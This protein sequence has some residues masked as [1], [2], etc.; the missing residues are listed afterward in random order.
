MILGD[1]R[2]HLRIVGTLGFN[3]DNGYGEQ[4]HGVR[5]AQLLDYRPGRP[6]L[7][8]DGGGTRHRRGGTRCRATVTISSSRR[9]VTMSYLAKARTTR[10]SAATATTGSRAA[11]ATMGSGDDGRI[12]ASR[13]STAFGEP[14]YGIAAIPAGQINAIIENSNGNYVAITNP[15]GALKYTV[16]L[17]PYSVDPSNAAPTTLMPRA[18]NANDI[19]YGGLGNDSFMAVPAKTRSRAPRRRWFICHEL[20]P[21]RRPDW[22]ADP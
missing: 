20:Q 4:D 14:L 8:R 2:Q 11:L 5:A 13:N 15:D 1:N 17:T 22:R 3:Y 16:D 6:D 21:G 7:R 19:I 18:L 9:S 12:F 10:S